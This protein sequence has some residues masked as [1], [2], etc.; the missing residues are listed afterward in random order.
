M[1]KA[2]VPLS[3]RMSIG[4]VSCML[5]SFWCA[6]NSRSRVKESGMLAFA[7][8]TLYGCGSFSC[9]IAV[10]VAAKPETLTLLAMV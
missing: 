3:A 5:G 9:S 10:A 7:I 4:T 2:I 6:K 8:G 1:W